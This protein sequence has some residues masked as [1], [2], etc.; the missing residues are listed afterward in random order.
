[1][2]CQHVR[3][4]TT[5]CTTSAYIIFNF[6]C[7]CPLH[8]PHSIAIHESTTS[9]NQVPRTNSDFDMC[10]HYNM[11]FWLPVKNDNP[12][13][14]RKVKRGLAQPDQNNDAIR[15]SFYEC[16]GAFSTQ[17]RCRPGLI[18]QGG[19]Y[20]GRITDFCYKDDDCLLRLVEL[21]CACDAAK[22]AA[23]QADEDRVHPEKQAEITQE[24]RKAYDDWMS[25]YEHHRECPDRRYMSQLFQ[26]L[27]RANVVADKVYHPDSVR[28]GDH[29]GRAPEPIVGILRQYD[30]PPRRY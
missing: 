24:W 7:G 28:L 1:M 23:E 18:A 16:K 14:E 27:K 22:K 15:V 9:R 3:V 13:W 11:E 25:A 30:A 12:D 17:A 20:G 26:K 5:L 6:E 10:I 21:Q 2:Y 8:P 19:C 4:D 29:P